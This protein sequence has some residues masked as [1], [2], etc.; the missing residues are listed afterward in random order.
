[1]A[2]A[3]EITKLEAAR[4]QLETA[5]RLYFSNGDQISIHTLA[6]ASYNVI[7]DIV[8][9]KKLGAMIVKD[10][11]VQHAKPEFRKVVSKALN[12]AENFFKHA[13]KDPEASF[14]FLPAQTEFLIFD[15]E[16]M[17]QKLTGRV[18][19]LFLAFRGWFM[20]THQKSFNFSAAEIKGWPTEVV[21][22]GRQEYFREVLP[23]ASHVAKAIGQ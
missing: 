13:D 3:I 12:A 16:V 15:A 8:R 1:M 22:N 19:P 2:A 23:I 6:A 7:R 4:R 11:S 18:S 14:N 9:K 21:K 10:L 5:I 20:M 17:Y